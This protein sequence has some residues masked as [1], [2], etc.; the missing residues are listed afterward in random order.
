VQAAYDIALIL[1]APNDEALAKLLLKI[2]ATATSAQR[3]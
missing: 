2:G 1:E 3:Q